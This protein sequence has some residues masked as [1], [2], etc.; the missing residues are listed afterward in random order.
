[1]SDTTPLI[2]YAELS[3]LVESEFSDEHTLN[4]S[5]LLMSACNDWPTFGVDEPLALLE[6]LRKEVV[7]ELTY[8]ALKNYDDRLPVDT[9]MWKKEALS[10]L[11]A[12]FRLPNT[13]DFLKNAPLEIILK[14]LTR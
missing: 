12:I 13:G 2:T 9:E 8:E 4:M 3:E 5:R 6:E 14:K 10:S 1:M 11:L 7:D